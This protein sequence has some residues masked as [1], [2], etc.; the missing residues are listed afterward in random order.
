MTS[1]A[2]GRSLDPGRGAPGTAREPECHPGRDGDGGLGGGPHVEPW[3]EALRQALDRDA[4]DV[5][6]GISKLDADWL[7]LPWLVREPPGPLLDDEDEQSR[8]WQAALRC[9][10]WSTVQDLSPGG[11]A[12]R[13]AREAGDRRQEPGRKNMAGPNLAD[14]R[15]GRND[16]LRRVARERCGPRHMAL[17]C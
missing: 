7:Q 6:E 16:F 9:M 17:P 1:P 15:G 13:I 10:E 2:G 4:A 12:K 8:L 11:L 5:A 14:R 3:I